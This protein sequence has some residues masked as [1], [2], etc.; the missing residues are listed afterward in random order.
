MVLS[1]PPA[2]HEGWHARGNIFVIPILILILHFTERET[3]TQRRKSTVKSR[4][5]ELKSEA[6]LES[7]LL[8]SNTNV[9][10]LPRFKFKLIK[11]K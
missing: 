6:G 8:D 4:T 7:K 1:Q 2:I 3:E 11:A 9:L 10:D 5:D